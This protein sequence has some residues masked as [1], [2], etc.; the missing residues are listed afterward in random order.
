MDSRIETRDIAALERR[1]AELEAENR[2]LSAAAVPGTDGGD[3][4]YRD[5]LQMYQILEASRQAIVVH[6]GGPALYFNPGLVAMLGLDA[7][8]D[9]A[10]AGSILAFVHENDRP[11]VLKATQGFLAG[12]SL[13]ARGEFRALPRDGVPLWVEAS[14]SVVIWDGAPAVVTAMNDITARKAAEQEVRRS[15]RL[16]QTAFD[17]CPDIMSLSEYV[18]GRYVDVNRTFLTLSGYAR[19][20]VLGRTVGELQIFDPESQQ[21]LANALRGRKAVRDLELR[22]RFR[23]GEVRDFVLSG[24]V[25]RFPEQDLVLT[26]AREVTE[27]RRQEAALLRSREA[28]ERANRTKSAF[29]AS[30][31]H[32]FR[33][34]LNAII[35]FAEIMRDEMLGPIGRPRYAEYAGDIHRSGAHLLAIINDL[36]DLSKLE[37][38]KMELHEEHLA[39][40]ALI[41]ECL[42]L[43]QGKADG[44]GVELARDLPPGLPALVADPRLMRQIL[45]NLLSNAVK[46]TPGGGRVTAGAEL[47]GAGLA[48]FVSD[49]GFGMTDEEVA[50]ALTPFG[51]VAATGPRLQ[52]GTGLGLPLARDLARLHGAELSIRSA[53]GEG[54]TVTVAMPAARLAPAG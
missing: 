17:A 37:A 34:P 47:T 1:I 9:Y 29:L 15:R 13:P 36:L 21:R 4:P 38:G 25:L 12:K 33:T 5:A 7:P 50:I 20:E 10:K 28:A 41:E 30:M 3:L 14:S 39:P 16:F 51:Q 8:D 24:E 31:S 32:E 19:E 11:A 53:R 35:G 26:V 52:E 48:L 44:T 45:L 22:G 6:R 27:R 49:T 40:G 42:R 18:S 43:V 23:N 2:R 54:T 46:F